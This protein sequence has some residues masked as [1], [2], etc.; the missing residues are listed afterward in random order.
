[1]FYFLRQNL[2]EFANVIEVVGH[3]EETGKHLW[4]KGVR[5]ADPVPEQT[6]ALNP[7]YGTVMADFF[8]T[9]IPLMSDRLLTALKGAGVD[10][11]DAYPMILQRPDTGEQWRNYKA[12]NFVGC[13]DAIDMKKSNCRR[14][15]TG[16]L[17]CESITIDPHAVGDAICF[18][19]KEGP[20][21]LVIHEEVADR[22]RKQDFVAV[23]IQKTEDYDGD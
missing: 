4:T 18:R 1:M 17:R 20:D 23:L 9:T 10:N 12:V 6:L 7:E 21:L 3:T 16:R 14:S 13:I 5:F 15:A 19:L 11:V 2:F 8:D 22:L